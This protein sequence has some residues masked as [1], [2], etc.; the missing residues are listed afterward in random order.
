MSFALEDG[1]FALLTVRPML[2]KSNLPMVF[3]RDEWALR[4]RGSVEAAKI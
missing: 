2:S 4:E 3:L 1:L